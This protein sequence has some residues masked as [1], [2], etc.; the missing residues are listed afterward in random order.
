MN[1]NLD[2]VDTQLDLADERIDTI[3]YDDGRFGAVVAK[4]VVT[5][6]PDAQRVIAEMARVLQPGGKLALCDVV[7]RRPAD[8]PRAPRLFGYLH[9]IAANGLVLETCRSYG[10]PCITL[11]AEKHAP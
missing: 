1:A 7:R 5:R 6:S 9:A 2:I 11:I 4:G 10:G 3:P 8:D